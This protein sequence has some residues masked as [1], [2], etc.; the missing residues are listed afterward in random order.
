VVAVIAGASTR[1]YPW[2]LLEDRRAIVDEL[3]G[4]PLVLF[5]SGD[6]LSFRAFDRRIDE[7]PLDLGVLS[8]SVHES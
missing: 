8:A 7:R 6:G 5:L 3:G 1:A 2:R 4:V